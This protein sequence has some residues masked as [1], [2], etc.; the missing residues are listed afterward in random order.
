MY[1]Y[2]YDIISFTH[3][4]TYYIPQ[5]PFEQHRAGW[6]LNLSQQH[7]SPSQTSPQAKWK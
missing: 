7:E 2:I 5:K 4:H 3:I 1:I 6:R